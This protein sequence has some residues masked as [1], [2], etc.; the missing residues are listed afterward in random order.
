MSPYLTT[1]IEF[2]DLKNVDFQTPGS[3]SLRWGSTQYVTQSFS[4]PISALYEFTRL[5]GPSFV[6]VGTTGALWYGATTGP[7]QGMSFTDFKSTFVARMWLS[8]VNVAKVG[9]TVVAED[10]VSNSFF[11]LGMQNSIVGAGQTFYI[12][13]QLLTNNNISF[14]ALNDYL[15]MADGDKSVKFDGTSLYFYGLPPALRSNN[16]PGDPS[17]PDGAGIST[18]LTSLTA[19]G[20]VL[21]FGTSLANANFGYALYAS[22]VNNRGF[23]SPT[24]PLGTVTPFAVGSSV[25]PAGGTF[26]AVRYPI[27]TPLQYGISSINLYIYYSSVTAGFGTFDTNFWNGYIPTFISN[28]PA[29]GS[30]ITW[31]VAGTST[32]GQSFIQLNTGPFPTNNIYQ[33]FGL[34]AVSTQVAQPKNIEF[35]IVHY[36]PRFNEIYENRL[37][38]SGFSS[39]PSTVWFSDTGEP[40]GITPDSNFEV[41]TNDGD[42]VTCLKSYITNLIIGKKNSFHVLYGDNPN[43][44]YLKELSDQYGILNNHCAV[45]NQSYLWFL[46]RKGIV[47]WNGSEPQVISNKIQPIFDS[48]NYNAALN[49]ACMIHD[50]LRNQILVGIPV[51]GSTLNNLTVVYDY[52]VQAW[53][54]YD[55]FTPTVFQA[56]Q[57]RN[58][59]KNAFYGSF[60][61]LV[62]YFGPSFFSDPG[63]SGSSFYIKTR[64][65]H[66]IGES[67][68]KVF[69]RL[70][71]NIDPPSVTLTMNINFFQDFGSSVVKSVSM[72]IG[73][74]QARIDFGISAKSLAFEA[75]N[76]QNSFPFKLH[77]FT[78]ESRLQRKV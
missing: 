1:P 7:S 25:G 5:E 55:G 38:L 71:M 62:N 37:F 10:V 77:G 58:N 6:F 57:G 59:T 69:R 48:M 43:N 64:F 61:G 49:S 11:Y 66:D 3:L 12:Q 72:S 15:F 20:D 2:L 16:F 44:F 8:Q 22:Y 54:T 78:I 32:G 60:S 34:T 27:L 52:L 23:E 67:Y 9:A 53:T 65:I 29:S 36:Y 26:V 56:I 4:A 70:F 17:F 50:K 30:T 68:Q 18:Y 46:D 73:S 24:W 14:T 42:Y 51:N 19:L 33:F 13:P 31:L 47:F 40:E 74:F 45:S 21:G 35:D 41:R 75:S 28:T 76:L 39:T 63:N